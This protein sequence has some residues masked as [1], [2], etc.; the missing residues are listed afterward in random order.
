MIFQRKKVASALAYLL[1]AGGAAV[2]IAPA[3]QAADI[4]VEVTGSNIR[5]V[6]GEGALPVQVITRE[7]IEREGI[8]TAMGI[9]ERLSANS[10]IGGVNFATS[11]GAFLAGF[12]SASLRGLGATRTLVLLNGRRLANT[13]FQGSMVDINSIPLSAIERVEVLLDG[14]SAI[15]GTDAIAGVINF[16]LRKDF[17]GFEASAYYGDSEQGGGTVQRYNASAGWGSLTRDKFNVFAT[18]DYNKTDNIAAN[19]RDYSKT[20]YIPGAPGGVFDKTSGNSIP[21][22]VS[23]PGVGTFN[24]ANPQCIP[25]YSFPT[26]GSPTQCRFD[27]ASVIDIA[28]PTENW[29]LYG[30]ARWAFAQNHE[31][32]LEASYAKTETTARVS[33][34]PISAA[35]SLVGQ[36]LFLPPTSPYYPH[37]F[38]QQ[39]GVD[40]QNLTLSWRSLELGPRTDFVT[41]EQ[42]RVVGGL[43]GLA[44]GWDYSFSVNWS[45]SE[46]TDEMKDGWVKESV[47]YPIVNS[48]AINPF[49]LNTPENIAL[50]SQAKAL[51]K[52][53]DNKGTMTDVNL[54]GSRDVWQLPA[55]P[56]ALALGGQWRHETWEQNAD[57]L[58]VSGD[59]VGSGGSISSLAE[60]SRNVWAIFGELNIPIVKTLEGNVALRYDD[61]EDVGTTWNPKVSLRWQPTQQVLVR[62]A[63]GTGFRAPSLPELFLPNF[64]GA[65]GNTYDDPLRCPTTGSARDCNAQFTTQLG[66]NPNLQPEES[67]NWTVGFILEPVPQFSFGVDYWHIKVDNMVGLPPEDPIF[68]NMVAAEAAGQLFR[69]APGSVGCPPA[70]QVGGIPCPVN[71]GI[72]NNANINQVTTSG[73]DFNASYRFP[74]ATWGQLAFNFNGTYYI[75]WDQ[76]EEGG[77]TQELIGTYAGGIASTVFG[78]G[79]TGAF[80]RWKHTANLGWNYG[81]WGA[82]LSQTYVHGYTEPADDVPTRKVGS[83]SVWNING[84]YTGLK[85]WTFTAGIN[86]LANSDPPFTRQGQSFQIGYDPAIAD[87]IGRFYWGKIQYAFK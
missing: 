75:Q 84:S 79:S 16:I 38:A 5:R 6:E 55:G 57:P 77:E 86:N 59:I 48:G 70:E 1:G 41:T 39:F 22:N 14:A 45:Q 73:V 44:W 50:M 28:P 27:Y 12:Q 13:A 18:I 61:Y 47:I 34:T 80:P 29:T 87:P 9:V 49:G 60:V 20:S 7:D 10:S 31:A 30:S 69:F 64:Y 67:T 15:Y 2:L 4:R 25:P 56:M 81:P 46:A 19:Q 37:A 68:S 40:G 51:G 54:T 62:G 76:R 24:P 82:N 36:P 78:S 65:T 71:F 43:Q 72:Q 11:E 3:A 52:M 53:L 33:P 83:W 21:A 66:G 35:T 63:W 8:Q 26:D 85:N 17:S 58:F 23:I 42:T 32:F 74:Q